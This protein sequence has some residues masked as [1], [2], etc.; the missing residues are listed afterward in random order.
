MQLR[1][2]SIVMV[3]PCFNICSMWL[4]RTLATSAS[5]SMLEKNVLLLRCK[6]S[7]RFEQEDGHLT[8]VEVDE[9][10]RLVGDVAAEV[11]SHDAVPCRVVLLVKFL[12]RG[13]KHNASVTIFLIG[14]FFFSYSSV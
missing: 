11:S 5:W 14:M 9:V 2:V 12:Q 6:T 7:A 8:Q 1:T 13:E 3:W 10:L 4:D